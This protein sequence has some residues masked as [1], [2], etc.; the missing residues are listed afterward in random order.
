MQYRAVQ[1]YAA[2]CSEI[3]HTKPCH[4]LH[5][6]TPRHNTPHHGTTLHHTT[7]HRNTP[8]H[9]T[10][11]HTT[12]HHITPH[13]TTTHHTTQHT[14][15]HHTTIH[16][17]TQHHTSTQ[18]TNPITDKFHEVACSV[19]F[20]A[21]HVP[22]KHTH[23]QPFKKKLR[24]EHTKRETSRQANAETKSPLSAFNSSPSQTSYAFIAMENKILAVG[25]PS[26]LRTIL[27]SPSFVAAGFFV[28]ILFLGNIR[29]QILSP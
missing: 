5:Y 28:R 11:R 20:C 15:P 14:K 27:P 21:Q 29:T 7:S 12:Q 6:T 17:A 18:H 24:G 8:Q 1:D 13:H 25:L 4:T 19:H 22:P 16:H 3:H 23:L 9:N 2:Q 10:P 26:L